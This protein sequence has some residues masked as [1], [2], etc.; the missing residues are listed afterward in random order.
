MSKEK[1]LEQLK[2]SYEQVVIRKVRPDQSI[3]GTEPGTISEATAKPGDQGA[4]VK[5]G[6]AG[7][8]YVKVS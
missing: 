2:R 5:N 6:D 4:V 1:L 8:G 7:T 3:P